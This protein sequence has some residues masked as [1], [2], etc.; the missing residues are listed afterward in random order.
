MIQYKWKLERDCIGVIG[1][2]KYIQDYET[3]LRLWMGDTKARGDIRH[4][5]QSSEIDGIKDRL[6]ELELKIA[7]L[8]HERLVHL[9]VFIT[10]ILVLMVS[11][12]LVFFVDSPWI[13][14]LTLVLLVLTAFYCA[15]YFLL[16]N[17]VQRWYKLYD[18]ISKL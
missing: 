12:A 17:T 1:V 8:Q 2:K 10:T 14:I 6:K 3:S 9:L 15:H 13:V 4:V 18:Q 7:W 5:D 16:E 11:F